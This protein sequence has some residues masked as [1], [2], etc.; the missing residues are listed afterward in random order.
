[1]ATESLHG[2]DGQVAVIT[3]AARNIGRATA[4][5]LARSGASVVVNAVNDSDGMDETVALIRETGGQAI[6]YLADVSQ[7]ES[8]KGL[9]EAA[10]ENFGGIDILI[11]NAALRMHTPFTKITLEEWRRV[12]SVILDASFLTARSAAPHMITA[13]RGRIINLGGLSAYLGAKERPHVISA[14]MGVVGLTRALAI[15]LGEHGITVNCVVP[16]VIDTVRGASAGT[17]SNLDD[18]SS[19]SIGRAGQPEEVADMV[20]H[21]CMPMSSYITGQVIH[22]NGGRFLP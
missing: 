6:A 8:A 21:L 16:G 14:K 12:T 10:V 15:E 9:I 17:A 11:N 2:L 19:D 20:R 4:I 22:V 7:E 3:G 5:A 13:K 1:M 18:R